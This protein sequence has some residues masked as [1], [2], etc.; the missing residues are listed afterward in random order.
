MGAFL[1]AALLSGWAVVPGEGAPARML[2]TNE[3]PSNCR[4]V[5]RDVLT[6]T[7][8]Q[9]LSVRSHKDR[10]TVTILIFSEGERPRKR[11]IRIFYDERPTKPLFVHQRRT[12]G[13]RSAVLA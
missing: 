13:Q 2:A 1:M 10:C 11:V 5:V 7:G 4:E 6:E 8:G 12:D 9:L 3:Q